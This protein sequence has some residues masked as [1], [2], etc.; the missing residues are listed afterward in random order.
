[1]RKSWSLPL[2]ELGLSASRG[3][4]PR[5]RHHHRGRPARRPARS[6]PGRLE[7]CAVLR[8][9]ERYQGLKLIFL[10]RPM[11]QLNII[12]LYLFLVGR[13]WRFRAGRAGLSVLGTNAPRSGSNASGVSDGGAWPASGIICAAPRHS[14]GRGTEASA[15]GRKQKTSAL[16]SPS[17]EAGSAASGIL[18]IEDNRRLVAVE[19][20]PNAGSKATSRA[21]VGPQPIRRLDL[22]CFHG[23]F[24]RHM[25]A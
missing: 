19:A 5:R 10:Q 25:K 20:R 7:A 17:S 12:S 22:A 23:P 1:M 18:D 11:R 15:G 16:T 8:A 3:A 21:P 6:R 24:H 13:I 4:S 14:V 9:N 2:T